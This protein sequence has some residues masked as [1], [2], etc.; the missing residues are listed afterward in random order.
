MPKESLNN[1][2]MSSPRARGKRLK[3]A[4]QMAGLSRKSLEQKYQESVPAL[5]IVGKT[6]IKAG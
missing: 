4:R 2:P 3:I 6:P 1:D 5:F